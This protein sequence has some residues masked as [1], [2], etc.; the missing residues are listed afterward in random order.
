MRAVAPCMPSV[1]FVI[2]LSA[3]LLLAQDFRATILGQVTDKSGAAVPDAKVTATRNDTAENFTT[4]T[5]ADGIYSLPML[6]PGAYTVTV[7]ALG[8]ART[9]RPNMTVAVDQ[10]LNLDFSLK[11]KAVNQEVT[12]LERAELVDSTTGS[13]GILFDPEQ[14]SNLPLNGR[15]VYQLLQLAEGVMFTQEEF[16]ASGH[17]GT[18]GWDVTSNYTINGSPVGSNRFMLNG[19]PISVNGMWQVAP[20]VEAIQEFKI[21]TNSYDAS[22]GRTGGGAVN[23]TLKSGT[24]QV[25]GSLFEYLRNNVLDA[26]SFQNNRVGDPKGKHIWNQF[27]GTVGGPIQKGKTFYFGSF[28]GHRERVPFPTVQSTIPLYLRPGPSGSVDFRTVGSSIYDPLTVYCNARNADGTCRTWYRQQFANNVIPGSRM[29]PVALKILNLYPLPNGPGCRVSPN[30]PNQCP[31]MSN[32]FATNNI[33][34]YTYNQEMVRLDHTRN[35]ANRFTATFTYQLGH[36]FRNRTGFPAPAMW[37]E[38]LSERDNFNVILGWTHMFSP[39]R[40]GDMRV[41]FGRYHQRF[42]ESSDFNFTADMLGMKMPDVPTTSVKTAPRFTW[43]SSTFANVIGNQITEYAT[44][45]LN[46]APSISQTIHRHTLKYGGEFSNI[47]YGNPAAGRPRGQFSFYKYET[48][49]NPLSGSDGDMVASMLL[50]YPDSGF[51]DWNDTMFETARYYAVFIQDDYKVRRNLTINVG[52]RWDLQG[53][54]IERFD[55]INAGFCFDCVSPLDKQ[56]DHSKYPMLPNPLRGGLIFAGK[57]GVSRSPY[58]TYLDQFQPRFGFAWAVRPRTVIRGGVGLYYSFA[59][60]HST[61]TGYAQS[62]DYIASL[63]G[64]VSPNPYAPL[65]NP[66]PDGVVQPTGSALGLG[67][68]LGDRINFDL[69]TR[70]VPRNWQWSFGVQRELPFKVLLDTKYIGSRTG[71]LPLG[72]GYGYSSQGT[73]WN[74]ISQEELAAGQKTNSYLDTQVPNP[75]Y[76]LLDPA[77]NM[78]KPVTVPVWELMRPYPQF[79]GMRENTNPAGHAWYDALQVRVEKRAFSDKPGR[80]LTLVATFTWQ[81]N[82]EAVHYLNGGGDQGK[83]PVDYLIREV[84]NYDRTRNLT[85]SSVWNLPVGKNGLI[86][87]SLTGWKREVI[88]G[89]SINTILTARSGIPTNWPDGIFGYGCT[90]YKVEHQTLGQWFQNDPNCYKAKPSWSTRWVPNRFSWIRNP[91]APQVSLSAGKTF[92]LTERYKLEVRGESFNTTNTPIFKGPAS[93]YTLPAKVVAGVATGLG[94]VAPEQ[95]NF[96]RS[97]QVSMKLR[98]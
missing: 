65:S 93:D 36:E 15:Q 54:V 98:F 52:L 87:R 35:E 21:N 94:T 51:V 38:M 70:R 24:N 45:H 5:N 72:A 50:G 22:I 81:K 92:N 17:S 8:F 62:T 25:H 13:G 26:N 41:S 63:D 46:M 42:P 1:L 27:G 47:Q 30:D 16:G 78:G 12:V 74:T 96:P 18:R 71:R 84:T 79:D 73:Q 83:Q 19:A 61:T 60:Q 97:I 6:R 49:R 11:V 40:L 4:K 39:S 3:G 53:S 14:T 7:E 95:Q 85:A 89:W 23:T 69:A 90:S 67:T 88:S 64:G 9:T 29:S 58:N 80:G 44:N 56:I 33:G 48:R 76:G 10:K 32:F 55:R 37:G 34:R 59:D 91:N 77:S 20:N 82:F 75:F 86:G 43:Q 68:S 31:A 57:G 66:F 2:C 28:E